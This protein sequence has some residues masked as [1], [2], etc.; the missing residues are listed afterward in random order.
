MRELDFLGRT[1]S[2]SIGTVT[3]WE[4]VIIFLVY[5]MRGIFCLLLAGVYGSR[6]KGF[7]LSHWDL[8]LHSGIQ[9]DDL[10]A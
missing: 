1:L 6:E 4:T 3:R 2:V 7:D 10:V 5:E 9:T 8:L